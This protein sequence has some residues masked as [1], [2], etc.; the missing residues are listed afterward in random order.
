MFYNNSG[1]YRFPHFFTCL[2]LAV[3]LGAC[4]VIKPPEGGPKDETPPVVKKTI[5]KNT[6]TN[7]SGKEIEITFDEYI[8]LN[9]IENQLIISP[10]LD[11]K[12]EFKQKGHSIVAKLESPLRENTTYKFYFGDAIADLNEKNILKNYSLTFSTGN[13][14]DSLG[15]SGKVLMASDLTPAKNALVSLY[16]EI[17]RNDSLPVLQKPLYVT[18]TNESGEYTLSN[19]AAGSYRLYALIDK[20]SDYLYTAG[21]AEQIAFQ[22]PSLKIDSTTKTADTL[23]LFPEPDSTQHISKKEMISL[24]KLM[25]IFKYPLKNQDFKLLDSRMDWCFSEISAKKDTAWFWIKKPIPDTL[26]ILFSENQ[27][28]IDTVS[29]S[30][31]LNAQRANQTV[32]KK[33]IYNH[34]L[35]SSDKLL[36]LI[37]TNPIDSFAL[38]KIR[39]FNEKDSTEIITEVSID[40]EKPYVLNLYYPWQED[41]SYKISMEQAAVTDIYGLQT[42]SSQFTIKPV[43]D[44]KLGSIRISLNRINYK[45]QAIVQLL[46]PKNDV[47]AERISA[48]TN[49]VIFENLA[50]GKYSIR[51]IKDENSNGKWDTGILLQRI[52]PEKITLLSKVLDLISGW[53]FNETIEL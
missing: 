24:H 31:K 23:Y 1:F 28:I 27:K 49:S 26:N 53:E 25:L 38:P 46:N 2:S 17:E 41:K 21:G 16:P 6:S 18:R 39:V 51:V 52:Q 22:N 13:Y 44:H 19:L 9:D 34:L 5:P 50:S 11:K 48:E 4:A 42:D 10:P 30:T 43:L 7:F 32:N 15:F 45:G 8:T 3:L 37:F 36:K 47:L 29:I 40:K 12:P 20:N 33:L 14:I 35:K